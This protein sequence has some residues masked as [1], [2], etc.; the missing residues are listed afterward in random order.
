MNK[1][2]LA[3]LAIAALAIGALPA[4][5]ADLGNQ[6][7]Y[8]AP[9]ITPSYYNWSGFYVGGQAG[10]AWADKNWTQTFPGALAGNAAAFSADGF[11]AGGQIGYNWQAGS[12][13]FGIEADA[14]WS[15]QSGSGVQTPLTAWT[16]STDVNWFGTVTG[17][18][19][20]AWDRVLIYGKGGFAWA[21]EDHSQTFGGVPV[22]STSSTPVGWTVGAGVEYA[23]STN[24][25]A[26]VEYN[27][28]DLGVKNI[29]F[30]NPG[31]PQ[32]TNAFDINQTMQ[33][34]KFGVNYRF[35]WGAPIGARY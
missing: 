17:R 35:D 24:W 21:N 6:P 5:A 1:T 28:I 14:N 12:W 26:K 34:V 19:G 3:G 10:G 25:S 7:V 9:T 18:V 22:S 33:V 15:N 29:G 2:F 8:R 31:T 11:I 13:V 30:A 4:A 16:S 20:Y 32:P 27:Y 23:L